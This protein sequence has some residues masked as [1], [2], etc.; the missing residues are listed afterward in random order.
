MVSGWDRL[1]QSQLPWQRTH[2]STFFLA[3]L[4]IFPPKSIIWGAWACKGSRIKTLQVKLVCL[5]GFISVPA[6][7][8]DE[9]I[10]GSGTEYPYT[11]SCPIDISEL[12]LDNIPTY[13]IKPPPLHALKSF[14]IVRGEEK[15]DVW[16]EI[17]V[18]Q[19]LFTSMSFSEGTLERKKGQQKSLVAVG[20][21]E[22]KTCKNRFLHG[23]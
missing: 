11:M 10:K 3:Y 14:F 17:R 1:P 9:N 20:W 8:M 5:Q 6:R 19:P 23:K 21:G 15:G 4:V 2:C 7:W 13:G 22:Y 16:A 12:I 18:F